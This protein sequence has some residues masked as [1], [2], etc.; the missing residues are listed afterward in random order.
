MRKLFLTIL[1]AGL[2]FACWGINYDLLY[3]PPQKEVSFDLKFPLWEKSLILVDCGGALNF[4]K[5]WSLHAGFPVSI[6]LTKKTK[7]ETALI[8]G[9]GTQDKLKF[10]KAQIRFGVNWDIVEANTCV[11][12]CVL[13]TRFSLVFR[14]NYNIFRYSSTPFSAWQKDM[15][16]YSLGVSWTYEPR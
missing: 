8:Y 4:N 7:I 13:K 11:F 3:S 2:T 1:I 14:V 5:G 16:D 6:S 12:C 15:L 9:L 10:A